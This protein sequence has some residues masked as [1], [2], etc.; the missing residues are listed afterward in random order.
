MRNPKSLIY[1]I[2]A[3]DPWVA[4]LIDVANL[5]GYNTTGV[6]VKGFDISDRYDFSENISIE[7]LPDNVQLFLG[8]QPHSSFVSANPPQRFQ[9]SRRKLLSQLTNNPNQWINLI[10]PMS[11][12][13][14]SSHLGH[15]VFVGAN[16]SIGANSEI[17][18]HCTINRNVS[19][20][21]NVVIAEGAEV[22]PNAAI[23]SGVKIER[24]ASIGAGA[25]ILNGITIGE[26]AIV[27]AGSV[28]T[29]DVPPGQIVFGIPA[30]PRV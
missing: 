7:D 11:W 20:G 29:K 19:I 8:Y 28:V 30:K 17:G 25:V 27:A 14:P 13:S 2:G 24:W 26:E 21:H 18:D 22:S 6:S 12:V 5:L 23:P 10:H 1:L 4:E 3:G 15:G 9:K 16:S